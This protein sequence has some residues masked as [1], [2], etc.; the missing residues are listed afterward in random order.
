VRRVLIQRGN[1]DLIPEYLGF[2]RGVVDS[3]DLPLNVSR[4]T[5]QENR[6]V[7]KI[8]SNLTKQILSHLERLA[9]DNKDRYEEFWKEHGRYFKLGYNDFLNRDRY[10]ALLRFNSSIC[11]N[12]SALISFDDYI[13]RTKPDQK[14]IYFAFGTSREAIALN[15]HMEIFKSKGIEVLYLFEPLDEFAMEGI[16]EYR[17]HKLVSVEHVDPKSLEKF[18]SAETEEESEPLNDEE[19]ERF[20]SFLAKMKEILGE[21]ITDVRI[22]S[23]LSESPCCTVNPDG[24]MTSSMQ[25]IIQTIS[26]D[27]TIPRKVLEVNDKHQLIKNLFTIFKADPD[28]TYL[29]SV[30]EQLFES[31]LLL[32]GYLMDPHAMVSR[33]HRLLDQSSG[34]YLGLK[35]G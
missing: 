8:S 27:T 12:A 3:E 5:L 35:K 17:G 2:V 32:E 31:S 4:E 14:E 15:P 19:K 9:K 23:R 33:T 20:D 11:E 16:R 7:A 30:V 26:K 34:W 18:E 24:Q 6:T 1:K 13:D 25:K 29:A 28:D 22:S 10:A 21:R